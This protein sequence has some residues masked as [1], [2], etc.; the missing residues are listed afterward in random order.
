M[1]YVQELHFPLTVLNCPKSSFLN[2]IKLFIGTV[3]W[4]HSKNSFQLT[5]LLC[6]QNITGEYHLQPFLGNK[7]QM[8][9]KITSSFWRNYLIHHLPQ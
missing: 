6:T 2:L 9:Q 3:C 1:V 4:S 8:P 7:A 5:E